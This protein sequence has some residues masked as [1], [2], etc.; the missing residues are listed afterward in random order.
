MESQELE[1]K[2][3][4]VNATVTTK[5]NALAKTASEFSSAAA[6]ATLKAGRS[7]GAVERWSGAVVLE[8]TLRSQ[9]GNSCCLDGI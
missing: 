1:E 3:Q 4:D 8:A 5:L 6:K 2:L 7:G 9:H